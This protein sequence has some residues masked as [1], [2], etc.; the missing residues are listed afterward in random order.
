MIPIS[1]FGFFA[2]LPLAEGTLAVGS[3]RVPNGDEARGHG[4][5]GARAAEPSQE[6]GAHRFSA[7]A[8]PSPAPP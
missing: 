1:R 4:D 5:D 3:E 2:L 7:L 8:A 6:R